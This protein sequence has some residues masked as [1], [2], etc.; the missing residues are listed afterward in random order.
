MGAGYLCGRRHRAERRQR[1]QDEPP[2]DWQ[3]SVASRQVRQGGRGLQE[4][5]RD[6]RQH[7]ADNRPDE[8]TGR[9]LRRDRQKPGR[10]KDIRRTA[11]P[12]RDT[13]RHSQPHGHIRQHGARILRDE[14]VQQGYEMLCAGREDGAR[15]PRHA[16]C[17]GAVQ[18][19][20]DDAVHCGQ[21]PDGQGQGRQRAQDG[22]GGGLGHD[23]DMPEDKREDSGEDARIQESLRADGQ[24]DSSDREDMVQQAGCAEQCRVAAR[25]AVQ[26]LRP[27]A[28]RLQQHG[29]AL[30]DKRGHD[31]QEAGA[32]GDA[33]FVLTRRDCGRCLRTGDKET[34]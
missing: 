19:H 8:Q 7:R 21:P 14:A 1:R 18:R 6:S 5:P 20:G 9:P 17:H 12:R 32:D 2:R 22:Q 3:R 25:D 31:E 10:H 30:A 33:G 13:H 23:G 26:A 34:A 16:V 15:G 29:A 27:Q 28:E 11:R 24:F 4:Q